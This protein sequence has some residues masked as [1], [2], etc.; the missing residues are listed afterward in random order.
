MMD[1]CRGKEIL[2][3]MGKREVSDI[4]NGAKMEPKPKKHLT[5]SE[6]SA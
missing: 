1:Y 2:I 4:S 5:Q 3:S 6:L